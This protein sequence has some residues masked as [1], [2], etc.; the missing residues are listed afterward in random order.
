MVFHFAVFANWVL[1]YQGR[2][3]TWHEKMKLKR[4]KVTSMKDRTAV[5]IC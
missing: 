3:P 2:K 1:E 4:E 5:L